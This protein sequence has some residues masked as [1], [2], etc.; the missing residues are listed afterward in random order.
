M[1]DTFQKDQIFTYKK[2]NYT[3]NRHRKK[4]E[5]TF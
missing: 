2:G 4:Y 1:W 3:S 5:E